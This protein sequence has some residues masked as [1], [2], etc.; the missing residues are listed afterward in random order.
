MTENEIKELLKGVKYPGFTRDIVS[1]GLIKSIVLD[2]DRVEVVGSRRVD[3]LR[4][5]ASACGAQRHE[6]PARH[7]P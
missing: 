1:F 2:A 4:T 6:D 3:A 7:P 5:A